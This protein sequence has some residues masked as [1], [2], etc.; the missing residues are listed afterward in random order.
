MKIHL[1]VFERQG[2]LKW[3]RPS[4]GTSAKEPK[5]NPDPRLVT[6]SQCMATRIFKAAA[7]QVSRAAADDAP[8]GGT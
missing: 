1:R 7:A 6:C 2:P 5:M 8:N 3:Q 4:C